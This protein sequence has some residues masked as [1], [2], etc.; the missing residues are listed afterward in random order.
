KLVVAISS[1]ALFDLDASNQ[2]FEREG[3]EAYRQYQIAH[4]DEPLKPGDAFHLVKKLLHINKLLGQQRV[5]V[6]LLSRNTADTG[7]RVFN[8]I[9]HHGLDI[10]KAAFC[11]GDSPYRYINAFNSHLFLSTNGY[12]VRQ[13]LEHGVA[14]ATIMPSKAA[15]TDDYKLRFAFDGDAVLFSDE[16]ERVYKTQ[17]LAEFTRSEIEAAKTPLSGGPFKP[18]LA[19]LQ[20]LQREF[21]EGESPIRTCLVTARAAPAHERV[22]RT[23]RAWN[24][25]IDESLFLGGQDKGPFLAA[26]NADVF[27]DDQQGHCESAR[28]HV[29]TGHVPHGIANQPRH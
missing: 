9:E 7:L 15:N 28:E 27:F 10:S 3:V 8:S 26:Y 29:A 12:D 1:R 20:M 13:G 2:V 17:G 5:E 24:I 18:F 6:I 19:A 14:A 22:V 4:E 11:G 16:A 21:K 25:K 23:L